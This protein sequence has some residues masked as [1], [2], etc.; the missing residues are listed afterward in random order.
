MSSI[1]CRDCGAE[2]VVGS[3]FC[4]QCGR[5]LEPP[6]ATAFTEAATRTLDAHKRV[7]GQTADNLGAH[8]T[9]PAYL[10]PEQFSPMQ[11]QPSAGIMAHRHKGRLWLFGFLAFLLLIAIVPFLVFML[12]KISSHRGGPPVVSRPGVPHAP[13]QPTVPPPPGTGSDAGMDSSF[14]Y[15]GA[16]TT[17][18]VGGQ[19]KSRV[20]QLTTR[21]PFDKVVDWYITK[22]KP[23][24]TIRASGSNAVLKADKVTAVITSGGDETSIILKGATGG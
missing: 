11:A 7:A 4:R 9:G 3:R 16:Q 12:V 23:T 14:V 17:L 1:I 6:A 8:P 5:Q 10:S 19:G 22:L 2:A 13:A 20:L 18:D 15:P 21:D 24:K